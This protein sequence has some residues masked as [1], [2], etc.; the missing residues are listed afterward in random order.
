MSPGEYRDQTFGGYPESLIHAWFARPAGVPMDARLYARTV[1]A[2]MRFQKFEGHLARLA[3][4][5][6][7]SKHLWDLAFDVATAI[8]DHEDAHIGES[9]RPSHY[10]NWYKAR[11]EY[12]AR[13]RTAMRSRKT[14]WAPGPGCCSDRCSSDAHSGSDAHCR[15][16]AHCSSG[17]GVGVGVSAG[18]E[19]CI[20]SGSNYTC[21]ST[22]DGSCGSFTSHGVDSAPD[23]TP[24]RP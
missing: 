19:V 3:Q 9:H 7:A 1:V 6:S 23:F 5:P 22:S 2:A 10:Y 16:D 20:H 12:Y 18:S 15:S 24:C 17:V 13:L 11:D 8:G 14:P 4:E 21:V